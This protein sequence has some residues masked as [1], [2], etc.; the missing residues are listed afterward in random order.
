[1]HILAGDLDVVLVPYVAG[2]VTYQ[3]SDTRAGCPAKAAARS[4]L[5]NKTF[6]LANKSLLM[7]TGHMVRSAAG[8]ADLNLFIDNKTA[9][10][11]LTYTSSKQFAD[12]HVFWTG[13]VNAGVHNAWL[14]SPV[15]DAWGCQDLGC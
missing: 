10:D 5:I 2:M 9:D 14:Q 13:T 4:K 1:M 11:G 15:A 3:T 6:T 12:G 8:R 7:V